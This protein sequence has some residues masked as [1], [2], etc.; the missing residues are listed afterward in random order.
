MQIRYYCFVIICLLGVVSCT[1]APHTREIRKVTSVFTPDTVPEYS[2]K[3]DTLYYDPLYPTDIMVLDT[4]LLVAQH[5]DENLIHVYSLCDTTLLGKFLYQGQGPDDV[6]WL[7]A[8][9]GRKRRS[10]IVNPV[11]FKIGSSLEYKP[12]IG[13]C[14]AGL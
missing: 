5:Q 13:C 7:Y 11:L 9:L 10:E 8:R 4:F 6:E 3:G 12:D 14:K 1:H 2:L